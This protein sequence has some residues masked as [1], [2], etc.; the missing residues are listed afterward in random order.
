MFLY[1]RYMYVLCVNTHVMVW[2][3]GKHTLLLSNQ[4]L[5]VVNMK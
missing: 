1:I 3:N 5:Q 2:C 4:N